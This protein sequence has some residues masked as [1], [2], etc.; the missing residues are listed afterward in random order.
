LGQRLY[1]TGL[2]LAS[3]YRGIYSILG[4]YLTARLAPH[5]PMH[6]ALILG[7]IGVVLSTAG[8]IAMWN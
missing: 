5:H 1:D 7:A 4:C 8:T 3:A 6:H 2:L